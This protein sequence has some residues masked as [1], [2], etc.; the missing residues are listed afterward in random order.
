LG[1]AYSCQKTCKYNEEACAS[2]C[3]QGNGTYSHVDHKCYYVQFLSEIGI[4]V[5]PNGTF[6][7]SQN[8][9]VYQM[10]GGNQPDEEM[11]N[12]TARTIPN[13]TVIVRST[14]DPYV[15]L[16]AL[17]KGSLSFA[18]SFNIFKILGI[19][20]IV[21][22]IVVTALILCIGCCFFEYEI[23]R[24]FKGNKKERV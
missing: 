5:Q 6:L 21:V 15:T 16:Y 12:D 24:F 23:K 1:C 17:T 22:G 20:F 19:V 2:N 13:I 18:S 7:N 3:T 10:Y 9:V 8:N 11:G 14:Q 4:V